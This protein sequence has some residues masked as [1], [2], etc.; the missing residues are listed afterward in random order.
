MKGPLQ[1]LPKS[2]M[3]E[4]AQVAG[5]PKLETQLLEWISERRQRSG[6]VSISKV[7][8]KALTL[9]KAMPNNIVGFKASYR[10][11]IRFMQQQNL[12]VRRQT[13]AQKLPADF[14]AMLKLL[15]FQ[16]YIMKTAQLGSVADRQHGSN[17]INV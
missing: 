3:A 4:H 11:G 7:W 16:Q 6:G 15:E 8:V 5:C 14:G 17:A 13:I 2:K 1:A 12:S 9:V 10:W